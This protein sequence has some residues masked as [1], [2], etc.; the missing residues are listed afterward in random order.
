[1]GPMG[2]PNIDSSLV[3]GNGEARRAGERGSSVQERW[4]SWEG[5]FPS[6]HVLG[7]GSAVSSRNG[8]RGEAQAIWRFRTVNALKTATGGDLV[9]YISL[10]TSIVD[11]GSRPSDH[12]FRSVSVGL[13]VCLSVCLCRVFLSRL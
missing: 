7:L 1:M 5:I 9:I 13:S 2:I 6:H 12:Y 4:G 10:Y 11:I 8:V 3:H